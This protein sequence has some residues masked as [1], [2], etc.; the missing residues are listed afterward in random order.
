MP[1]GGLGKSRI[2]FASD[3]VPCEGIGELYNFPGEKKG[4]EIVLSFFDGTGAAK[5][6]EIG[7]RACAFKTIGKDPIGVPAISRANGWVE[8]GSEGWWEGEHSSGGALASKL[9]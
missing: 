2:C 1:L 3:W 6:S 8:P 4:E 5:G 7:P 9:T